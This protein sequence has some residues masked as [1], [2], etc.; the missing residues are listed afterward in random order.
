M[1]SAK[2]LAGLVDTG[3]NLFRGGGMQNEFKQKPLPGPGM[4]KPMEGRS[5][6]TRSRGAW[7]RLPMWQIFHNGVLPPSCVHGS[8][9]WLLVR[10]TKCQRLPRVRG[11]GMCS[12]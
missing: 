10:I 11:S 6:S 9:L 2:L 1:R 4:E 7:V 8:V 3:K 5:T 12:F